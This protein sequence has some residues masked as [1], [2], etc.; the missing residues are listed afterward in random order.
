MKP[1]ITIIKSLIIIY[2]ATQISL[3]DY[4]ACAKEIKIEYKYGFINQTGKM[5]ISPQFDR[6]EGFSDGKAA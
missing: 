5:V 2:L 3:G 4:Q 6:A 1:M